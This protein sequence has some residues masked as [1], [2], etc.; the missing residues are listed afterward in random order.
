VTVAR[1]SLASD[2]RLF[3]ILTIQAGAPPGDR[4]LTVTTPTG[5]SRI[6]FT[7]TP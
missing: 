7:V 1:T 6:R 5:T 3:A 4:E 2:K